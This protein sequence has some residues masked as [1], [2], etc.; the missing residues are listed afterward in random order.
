MRADDKASELARSGVAL[1][2]TFWNFTC[3]LAWVP[4]IPRNVPR[5]FLHE[6]TFAR[7]FPKSIRW[8][9]DHPELLRRPKQCFHNQIYE[10][11]CYI[12]RVNADVGR[13]LSGKFIS[14]R[15]QH[16]VDM[17]IWTHKKR[18]S[19]RLR[20]YRNNH[21]FENVEPTSRALDFRQCVCVKMSVAKGGLVYIYTE[22]RIC[23]C[24]KTGKSIKRALTGWL[25][26]FFVYI[27]ARM[28]GYARRKSRACCPSFYVEPRTSYTPNYMYFWI[29]KLELTSAQIAQNF[30]NLIFVEKK[31]K[32][33]RLL[34]FLCPA[35]ACRANRV[36]WRRK[37]QQC[38]HIHLCL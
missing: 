23:L 28:Q 17:D 13:H 26:L 8:S 32:N 25:K 3:I 18:V 12:Y 24:R 6:C 11:V 35:H 15:Q 9:R 36:S 22:K 7:T 14:T 27:F 30:P 21:F 10:Y 5:K 33:C 4:C 2:V 37:Q 31:K 34:D 19:P 20:I 29:M 1:N 38:T 16:R